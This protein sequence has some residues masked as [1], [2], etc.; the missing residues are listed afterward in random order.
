VETSYSKFTKDVLVI[1]VTNILTSLS[2][3]VL[4]PLLTKTLGAHDYGLWSQVSVTLGFAWVFINLG[5]PIAMMRFLPAKTDREEIREEFYS[6]LA[7]V[8]LMALVAAALLFVMAEPIASSF[9][10]GAATIVR[11]TAL[12]VIVSALNT[13]SL[14]FFRSFLQMKKYSVFLITR[15]Y[16]E[17]G[18]MA[19]L[20]LNGHGLFSV[21]L[22]MLIVRAIL[23]LVLFFLIRA[24]IG[25]RIP[26]F[27]RIKE[28]IR[29]G[30]PTVVGM[31]SSS[32]VSSSDRYVIS[33]FLGVS[34]VGVYSA[35]Y[36]LGSVILMVSGVLGFVLPPTLAK[37]YDEGRMDEV[38]TH[39]SYSLKYL[40]ALAIP[41]VFGATLLSKQ[42]LTMFSTAEIASQ[43]YFIL[44]IIALSILFSGVYTVIGHVILLVKK[45]RIIAVAWGIAAALNLGLNI[46]V[47]PHIGILGAAITTLI[48][49]LL[50][51]SIISYYSFRE[52]RFDICW[53]FIFKSLLAS[54]IMSAAIWWIEPAGTAATLG[55]IAGGVI[56]YA[57]ALLLLRGFTR[58][59]I[60]FFTRLFRR[61]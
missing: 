51:M 58:E 32:I 29:Y 17:I 33:Y 20:V 47:V 55:T 39:L 37:L 3:V 22:A 61:A 12:I 15:V 11:L 14:S 31:M 28:Y 34:A 10:D 40:L 43:G 42:V 2:G 7:V 5:L 6:V 52:I 44:P 13:L 1:G 8:F 57:A 35:G 41:F 21:I 56:I 46:L 50:A 25:L 26:H 38:K 60:R 27:S 16:V 23:F 4:L 18:V 30:L 45:T 54:L 36:G 48:A 9:F 53:V 49:Y 24:Q 59:E 19:Y